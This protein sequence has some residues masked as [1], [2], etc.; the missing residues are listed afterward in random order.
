MISRLVSKF[1]IG[2][3]RIYQITLSPILGRNCRYTPTCS[4]YMIGAIQIHGPIRGTWLG[5]RR[6]LRCNTFGGWGFD[7]VPPKKD[8]SLPENKKI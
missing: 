2:L 4:Q 7:P 8:N 1:L 6:I 5:M 3:V